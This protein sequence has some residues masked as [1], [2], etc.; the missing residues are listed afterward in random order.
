MYA[1]HR[2]ILIDLFSSPL[3]FKQTAL[4]SFRVIFIKESQGK[5]LNIKKEQVKSDD[6][7]SSLRH[8]SQ[9]HDERQTGAADYRYLRRFSCGNYFSVSHKEKK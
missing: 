2:R 1:S 6:V 9:S 5:D 7:V 8:T 3:T 4:E